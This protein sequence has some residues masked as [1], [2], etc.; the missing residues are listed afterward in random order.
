M[1][2]LAYRALLRHTAQKTILGKTYLVVLFLTMV[3]LAEDV[4]AV[5][6]VAAEIGAPVVTIEADPV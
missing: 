6:V 5:V 1:L 3:V 2:P 4:L